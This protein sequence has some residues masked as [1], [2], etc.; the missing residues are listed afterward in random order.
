MSDVELAV[1]TP[2][3]QFVKSGNVFGSDTVDGKLSAQIA[4]V[5]YEGVRFTAGGADEDGLL[6]VATEHGELQ[7]QLG[8]CENGFAG[9][10]RFVLQIRG[11]VN[12]F[13]SDESLDL[14]E[15]FEFMVQY[16]QGHV[17][18]TQFAVNL[19]DVVYSGEHF[20]SENSTT[21]GAVPAA[22]L[23]PAAELALT[24][25]GAESGAAGAVLDLPASGGVALVSADLLPEG[26]GTI[27]AELDE[28]FG[29][30]SDAAVGSADSSGG[31]VAGL[32]TTR[33]QDLLDTTPPIADS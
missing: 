26:S 25:A 15:R 16:E 27:N 21:E 29:V 18:K 2:S 6:R 30:E 23:E 13:L 24:G 14:I 20:L 17:A 9:D 33:T 32:D 4:G 28:F 31:Y 22:L 8:N 19:I 1:H 10:Y 3:H 5:N 12:E 7:L 11:D